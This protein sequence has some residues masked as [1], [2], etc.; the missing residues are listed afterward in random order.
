MPPMP[1]P[2]RSPGPTVIVEVEGGF[3]RGES[4]AAQL[5]TKLRSLL[6]MGYE[7]ILV[8]VAEVTYIDSVMLGAIVQAYASAM[9]VGTT[10]KLLNATRRVKELLAVT[11]LNR[12]LETVDSDEKAP[13]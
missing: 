3:G 1:L 5:Q 10:V 13:R 2:P 6:P 8:N 4:G 9:R 7:C 11:K 12:V